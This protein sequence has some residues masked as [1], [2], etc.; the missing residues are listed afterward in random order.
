MHHFHQDSQQ[1]SSF[2]TSII[3]HMHQ[4]SIKPH[5][6]QLN[7]SSPSGMAAEELKKRGPGELLRLRGLKDSEEDTPV[8]ASEA[9]PG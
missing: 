6:V 2:L 8:D 5:I 4:F 7:E 1:S 9:A 3:L